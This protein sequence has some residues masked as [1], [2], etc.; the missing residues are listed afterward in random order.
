MSQS[1]SMQSYCLSSHACLLHLKLRNISGKYLETDADMHL[2]LQKV[3]AE[4]LCLKR[5]RAEQRGS[6]FDGSRPMDKGIFQE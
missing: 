2:H 4:C 1:P 6:C 5:R 3:R